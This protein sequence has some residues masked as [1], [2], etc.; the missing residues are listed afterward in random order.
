MLV[1]DVYISPKYRRLKIARVCGGFNQKKKK[2]VYLCVNVLRGSVGFEGC[3]CGV[4]LKNKYCSE[5]VIHV[6]QCL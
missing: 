6:A 2:S 3:G 1:E 5:E 4:H